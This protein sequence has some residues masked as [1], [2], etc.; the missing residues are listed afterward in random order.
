MRKFFLGLLSFSVVT[1]V[2]ASCLTDKDFRPVVGISLSGGG[3]KGFAHVGVLKVLEEA[4]VPIDCIT[5]TSI[6]SIIGGLYA[7]GYTAQ[8]I[9]EGLLKVDW[10]RIFKDIPDRRELLLEDKEQFSKSILTLPVKNRKIA[11]PTGLYSGQ[12]L[13]TRL[14]EFVWPVQDKR[15]FSELPIPFGS[16]ATDLETGKGYLITEGPLQEA[17]RASMSIPSAFTPWPIQDRL[18]ADGLLSRNLPAQDL[19]GMGAEIVIGVDVGAPLYKASELDS[20]LK[21]FDQSISIPAAE[22]NRE[23]AALCDVL[24]RPEL[25]ELK[26][27]DFSMVEELIALGEEAARQ[28][29][30]QIL[31]RLQASSVTMVKPRQEDPDLS[32]KKSYTIRKIRIDG[33]VN[34]LPQFVEKEAG[35]SLPASLDW[36]ATKQAMDRLYN[37][38]FFETVTY[39]IE[40]DV[41]VFKVQEK[42]PAQ[43]GFALHYD[44]AERASIHGQITARNLGF[45]NSRTAIAAKFGNENELKIESTFFH[46]F[47]HKI[48]SG[49]KTLFEYQE[50]DYESRNMNLGFTNENDYDLLIGEIMYGTVRSR[51]KGFGIGLRGEI[52]NRE[53]ERIRIAGEAPRSSDL[54]LIAHFRK[55]TLNATVYPSRGEY[56]DVRY[57]VTDQDYSSDNDSR[58]LLGIWQRFFSINSRISMD[59]GFKTGRNTGGSLP[60]HRHFFLGGFES[61]RSPHGFTG[62]RYRGRYAENMMAWQ[63]GMQYRMNPDS[64]IILRHNEGTLDDDSDKLYSRDNAIKGTGVSLVKLTPAGPIEI[65]VSHSTEENFYSWVSLGYRY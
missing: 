17:M 48:Q 38:S 11:L 9:E 25:S 30:P 23:Q 33:L 32:S 4:G 27:I 50:L 56:V 49:F 57:F 64:L 41:L 36:N 8:Q 58:Y 12:S 53:E 60:V 55:D 18:L 34:L 10:T 43:L 2:S 20:L 51:N 5:G 47:G 39:G 46:Q 44:T 24:I 61:F 37:T 7:S 14:G 22:S 54:G 31:N 21:I 15:I 63:L 6:G 1:I 19:R 35:I 52:V 29:L 45:N 28:A 59:M 3:A 26:S 16:L 62:V 42:V 40:E 65:G 13:L